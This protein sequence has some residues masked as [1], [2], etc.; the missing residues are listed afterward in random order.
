MVKY[1]C[2]TILIEEVDRAR[3]YRWRK[4]CQ[5]TAQTHVSLTHHGLLQDIWIDWLHLQ[6]LIRLSDGHLVLV[7]LLHRVVVQYPLTDPESR[8]PGSRGCLQPWD[9]IWIALECVCIHRV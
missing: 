3:N 4:R 2:F 6:I 9:N 7:D 8:C 5:Q 1:S